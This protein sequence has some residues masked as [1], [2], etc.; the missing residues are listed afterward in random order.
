MAI[1]E[2]TVNTYVA[3]VLREL[4]PRWERP[5]AVV[6][7]S[8]GAVA[9]AGGAQPDILMDVTGAC[10]LMVEAEFHPART[11]DEDAL[12]RIGQELAGD[13]GTVET[14]VALRYPRRLRAVAEAQLA[15]EL[16]SADDLEWCVWTEGPDE[17]RF[18]SQGWLR[19][20]LAD[21]AGTVETVAVSQRRVEEAANALERAV[22]GA[23]AVLET[24]GVPAQQKIAGSLHQA[25]GEQTRRMAA[26]IVANAFLFQ[27]AVTHTHGT[28]TIDETRARSGDA[29]RLH[30]VDVLDVWDEILQVNYW[31]IFQI[32]TDLILPIPDAAAERFCG[33]LARSA[34]RLAGGGAVTAQDLAG[35]M[36]GRLITDRK[37][38]ATFYTLPESAAFL[39]ELAVSRLDGRVD[40]GDS[41]AVTGLRMADLACGTGALLSAVYRRVAA[42][43]RR[44]GLDDAELHTSMIEESL[45]G[46]DI[47]PAAAHLT[48]TML[49]SVHPAIG[50]GKCAIHVLPFGRTEPHSVA[51]GSLDLLGDEGTR[52]LFGRPGTRLAGRVEDVHTGQGVC[53]VDDSSLDLCIM[54]PPFTSPTNHETAEAAGVPVPSFAGFGTSSADQKDMSRRLKALNL[55]LAD[56]DRA[57]HG[58]AG[59]ASNFVDLAHAKLRP[60]GVLALILPFAAATGGAW[61]RTRR[62]LEKHYTGVTVASIATHGSRDR[63]FS[64]DTGMAEI[65]LVAVKR[66]Q[67][68]SR[69][70]SSPVSW[71]SLVRRPV[72]ITEAVETAHAV[73]ACGHPSMPLRL[74]LGDDSIGHVLAGTVGD[75]GLA[76]VAD[77]AVVTTGMALRD[78]LLHLPRLES[79]E[80]PLVRLSELG[81]PGPVDRDI[82]GKDR[83]TGR[84]RGPFDRRSRAHGK[85]S[86]YPMLWAHNAASGRES[87]LEVDPDS[88]GVVRPSMHEAAVELWRTATRLHISRDFQIN[89]Q[90]LAACL[91]SEVCLGGRAWPSF[92]LQRGKWS[93]AD[94]GWDETSRIAESTI[95][96][97]MN[98]SLGLLGFWMTGT[99]QHQGRAALT[100]TRLGDLVVLD[101]RRLSPEQ[102]AEASTVY[103]RFKHLPMRPANEAYRDEVRQDLDRA[104]LCD[105]LGLSDGILKPLALLRN[106]WCEEPS[107][108][109]G[110]A[111]RPRPVEP[112]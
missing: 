83:Q 4:H 90:S 6:S 64:A 12:G 49:S 15:E 43:V 1:T 82:D 85:S 2:P 112:A 38:L 84:A 74:E 17:T 29:R 98:T 21:L 99:R 8:T 89:S 55:R 46:A 56:G 88:E 48:T 51:L 16:R 14:V 66:E 63:A 22:E 69:A 75:G 91:S 86:A 105:L 7:Q 30:K 39:A 72:T 23:A 97:W 103:E 24:I 58:N 33:G 70:V 92:I 18:P 104:V 26:S 107:V 36:F 96:L 76:A 73:D 109:G 47:M 35:Q 71:P 41:A 68:P 78:G 87:C 108:H 54:N 79:E 27:T 25:P 3:Q 37:F 10:P 100:V 44:A 42:R 20:G 101:P 59:L 111:T 19:G 57:G 13:K 32:A 93:G 28:P 52:S 45:I 5:G 61:S 31:P 80:L 110:K 62:L 53:R 95:A 50:F 81:V 94:D 77:P 11:L 65:A 102:L 60:G 9:G 67:G 34:S 40:W 106:T